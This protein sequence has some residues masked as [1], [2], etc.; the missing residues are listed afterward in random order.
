MNNETE[1]QQR[2]TVA[3]TNDQLGAIA[4]V[5]ACA[6]TEDVTPIIMTVHITVEGGKLTAVSTDRYRLARLQFP[7]DAPDFSATINAKWLAGFY[8][9]V[10][11]IKSGRDMANELTLEGTSITLSNVLA[12][13]TQSSHVVYGQFPPI[14]RLIPEWSDEPVEYAPLN[15]RAELLMALT[16]LTLPEDAGLTPAKRFN[17][18]RMQT[19]PRVEGKL[20]QPVLFTQRSKDTLSTLEFLIQPNLLLR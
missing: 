15:L 20:T 4:S 13:T 11:K 8:A 7:V 12:Q 6:A 3:L 17:V 10:K 1:I 5:G 2:V 19:T 16:K 9:S 18:W 14:G